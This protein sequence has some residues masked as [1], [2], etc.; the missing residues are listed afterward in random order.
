MNPEQGKTAREIDKTL[1]RK[2][3][4][5]EKSRASWRATAEDFQHRLG[6]LEAAMPFAGEAAWETRCRE[7]IGRVW[8]ERHRQVSMYGFNETLKWGTGPDVEWMNPITN[9]RA[10]TLESVLRIDYEKFS[11]DEGLPTWMHL[12]R[13][14]MAEA[15]MEED[16]ERLA[17]ELIQVAALCVSWV[18]RITADGDQRR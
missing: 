6:V 2:I 7:I 1:A 10:E 15:F 3:E 13:E 5:L 16:P 8:S 18:E 11:K 12:V 14:E 17:E 9:F 4:R